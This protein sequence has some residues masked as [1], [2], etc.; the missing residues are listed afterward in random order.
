MCS[1]DPGDT[2]LWESNAA[3]VWPS[4]GHT[5]PAKRQSN[6]TP[7]WILYYSPTFLANYDVHWPD[8]R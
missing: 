7:S 5:I 6:M 1:H 8:D 3:I 4:L 2:R